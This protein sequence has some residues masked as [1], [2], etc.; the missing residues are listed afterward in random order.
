M[1]LAL[2]VIISAFA[3][4]CALMPTYAEDRP[5]DPFGV[6]TT[7][8]NEGPLVETWKMLREQLY[9]D[10]VHIVSCSKFSTFACSPVTKAVEIVEEARQ[11]QGKAQIGHLNR[12]INLLIRPV[13]GNWTSALE[14]FR[15][16]AGDCKAYAIAKYVALISAGISADQIR[17]VIVYNWHRSEQHMI[18]V[19]HQDQEWLILDNLTMLLLKDYEQRSYEPLFVLDNMGVRS[20][21]PSARIGL[22]GSQLGCCRAGLS[23][24]AGMGGR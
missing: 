2:F 1:R 11:Q 14:A 12:S 18:V 21:I 20:Y 23:S 7:E 13:P 5:S 17:L 3:A 19:V 22:G 9:R 6:A 15:R 8:L 10:N 24:V 16:R 4:W